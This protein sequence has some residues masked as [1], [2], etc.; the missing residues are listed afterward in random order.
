[1]ILTVVLVSVAVLGSGYVFYGRFLARRLGL[2]DS[3]KTPACEMSDGV[4]FVPARAPMLLGQH[5][6]AIAAAGPIVGPIL[7]GI[8]FGWLPALLWI[9]LGA[10]FVGG[11]HDFASMFASVRHRAA[12]IGEIVRRYMSRT[13]WVLFL[14][15]VWFALVYVI[16]AFTDITAQTF[17]TVS[18]SEAFGPGVAASSVLY[19]GVGLLMGIALRRTKLGLGAATAIFVPL[20]LLVI[21][22]GTKLPPSVSEALLAVPVKSWEV[23]LLLYC[24]AASLI[25]MWLLLQPRGYLGGWFLYLTMAVALFGSLFGGY[26]VRYPA[27]NLDGL[28]SLENAKPV[29]PIVFITVACGACSGFHGIVSS[30]TT[31]KQICRESD[32]RVVGYGSMILEGLVAVLALAT[33][34]MLPKG[35]P[36]L[37]ADPN[38]IYASGLS[39]YLSTVGF[40]PGLA[41]SFALVAFSTFVYDTLDVCTR[42]ARY[43]LQELFGWRSRRGAALAAFVTLLLPLAFLMSTEEKGY[44]VAWPIFGTSNQ[45]LAS[46]TLLAVSMYL[47]KTGRRAWF[48]V[49]PMIF[50]MFFTLWALVLQIVPFLRSVAAGTA[51]KPD[52]AIAGVCGVILL[53]LCGW[54]VVEAFRALAPGRNRSDDR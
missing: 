13:S 40:D 12:S 53:V 43:I 39:R 18:A 38:V 42:L 15:F 33:V 1:M 8:W 36:A 10:I 37:A 24:F 14:V 4:D 44:L 48:A 52:V 17:R 16:I 22:V 25:P 3:R 2:D 54:L 49:A 41:L 7:A 20:V 23:A 27:L 11:V 32:T 34:M 51:V 50:M 29:I 6:S 46:L 28:L 45:L 30:G 19:L 9:L 31:S 21:W 5:F 26:A 47:V 35:D